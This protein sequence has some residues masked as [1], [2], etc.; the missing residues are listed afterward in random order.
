LNQSDGIHPNATGVGIVVERI[1]PAVE[2][3]LASLEK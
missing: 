3:L 2:R 1:L